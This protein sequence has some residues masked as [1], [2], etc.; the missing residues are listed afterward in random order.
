[1]E[2]G[3]PN[4][5]PT[6]S[7]L[8]VEDEALIAMNQTAI[9]E[10]FGYIVTTAYHAEEAI[11]T[12]AGEKVDLVLMDIDLG[13]GEMDGTEA[14]ELIL[15]EHDLPIV[16]LTSHS[17]EEMVNKVKG[18][19][20]YGYV[21]KNSGE[22][23]LRESI[24]MALELFEAHRK[25]KES[26]EKYRAA[27]MTSPD[28]VNIN[29]IDGLYIDVN[30]GFTKLTGFTREDVIEKLSSEIDIWAHPEDREKLIKGL[31]EDG[32]VENLESEFKRKDGSLTTALMSA[33]L[34]RIN[35][36]PH[37]LSITR[38]ISRRKKAE[39]EANKAKQFLDNISDIAYEADAYGNVIYVNPAAERIIGVRLDEIMGNPFEP[40]FIEQD[41]SSLMEVY[42]KTLEGESLENILTFN[43]GATCHFTTLPKYNEHGDIVGTFGV[44]RDITEHRRIENRL[45]ERELLYRQLLDNAGM[46]IGFWKT[47]GTLIFFNKAA[48]GYMGGR[49]AD[50]EGKNMQDIFGSELSAVYLERIRKTIDE[51]KTLRFE[52]DRV[53]SDNGEQWFSS[54]YNCV[55]ND[56][57]EIIG[58]EIISNDIT[59]IKQAEENIKESEAILKAVIESTD[60]IIVF[61]DREGKA[62]VYNESFKSI[63]KE[64]FQI[65]AYPGIRTVDYLPDDEKNYW[66][67]IIS[68]VLRGKKK[69]VRFPFTFRNG[70][71]REY[72]LRFNP[73]YK[74]GEVIGFSEINRDMTELAEKE[75]ALLESEKYPPV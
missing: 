71:V 40:L 55:F 52:S 4:E 17:E 38:D 61:R 22:F 35:G 63:V 19:T 56:K 47:D 58:V 66:E 53:E 39:E 62:A 10:K 7:I 73:V 68:D 54:T 23:V 45:K 65:E 31:K 51:N 50:F 36:E 75:K 29:R 33:R 5:K 41:R 28:A 49:P 18:I 27:F 43:S 21:L 46:G 57:Q 48:A 60:D 8:L 11:E 14:A 42:K 34:I 72:E 9:L 2:Y 44:A 64:L 69:K 74:N 15:R 59:N 37:I 16:F 30:E 25:T 67:N 12:V 1:M 24:T 70:E 13:E 6:V 3:M 26:E 32:F 20:R